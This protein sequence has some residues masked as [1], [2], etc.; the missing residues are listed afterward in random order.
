MSLYLHILSNKE[1]LS[2]AANQEMANYQS[3]QTLSLSSGTRQNGRARRSN[4]YNLRQTTQ[5][6]QAAL[7][8]QNETQSHVLGN[9]CDMFEFE[10]SG[11]TSPNTSWDSSPD[12]SLYNDSQY[13]VG[14]HGSQ[15]G[16][17]LGRSANL[18]DN[19]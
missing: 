1:H 2:K 13:L 17:S 5:R 8:L 15:M 19:R 16:M 12:N 11:N 7:R 10:M 6:N 4:N 9:R 14:D 3:G 18:G